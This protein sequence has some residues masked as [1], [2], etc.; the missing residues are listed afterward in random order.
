MLLNQ[1]EEKIFVEGIAQNPYNYGNLTTPVYQD[2]IEEFVEM[3]DRLIPNHVNSLIKKGL[4]SVDEDYVWLTTKG[5]KYYN[6]IFQLK[7]A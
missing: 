4:V 5:V 6:D 7:C 3:D 2:S 1:I